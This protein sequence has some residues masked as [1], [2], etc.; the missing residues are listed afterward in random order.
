MP[1]SIL[2]TQC[3]QNDFVKLLGKHDPL[4][5]RL[6]IGYDEAHRLMGELPEEGPV[7]RLMQWAYRTDPADLEVI[8]IRDWHDANDPAQQDHLQQ[9]GAHCLKGTEGAAFAF[10]FIDRARE[11]H[12]VTASGLNDFINTE[13]TDCLDQFKDQPI[14]VGIVGVWTEAKVSFLSYELK[15]R[16]PNFD[17]AV[18]S[19]LTASSSTG[20]HYI[21]LD[22][23]R[24][25]LGIR[26]FSSVGDFTN[27]LTGTIPSY[28]TKNHRSQVQDFLQFEAGYNVSAGDCEL[29]AQ[30][31]REAKTV[32][33]KVLDG[34]YSGNLVLKAQATDLLGHQQVPTVIKIGERSLIAQERDSFERI[35]EILG[36]SAPNIVDFAENNERG[37]IKY[38]YA[39]MF[40]EAVQTFQQFYAQTD[41]LERICYFLDVIFQRQLGRLYDAARSERLNLLEYYE[42][43]NRYAAGVRQRAETLLGGPVHGATFDVEGHSC[44]NVCRFY[45]EDLN[46]LN[47]DLGKSHFMAYVHGD[48]NGA[49]III[50]AQNNVWLI[51]FFHTHLGHVLKDLIKFENDLLF[52]FTSINSATELAEGVRLINHLTEM[53][54]LGNPVDEKA[55]LS[56]KYP[57][58]AKAQQAVYRLR[59]YY[60]DLIETD[61]DPYQYHVAM[62]RYAMHTTSFEECNDW[63]RKLALYTAGRCAE[64]MVKR[65]SSPQGL[66]VDFINLPGYDIDRM[67]GLT[68]L[69]GRKDRGRSIS[70]DLEQLREAQISGVLCLISEDEFAEYGVEGLKAAYREFGFEV[71]YMPIKDQG[72][73]T[74]KA[75]DDTLTWMHDR[76]N[77]GQKTLIHCVGGLGRSGTLAACYLKQKLNVDGRTAIDL[78]RQSRSPR[79]IETY[80]QEQFVEDY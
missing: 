77:H 67:I 62:M 66:R 17:L 19:A 60:P 11:D 40:D 73:P 14:K 70:A 32:S 36:N 33:F 1:G 64:K 3:L 15:T 38:R 31:Y 35:R 9:F 59:S 34:G 80:I 24:E 51:D 56:F 76:L 29:L 21:A 44:Y 26:V 43:S 45:E 37:G 47:G 30:L 58:F 5:N 69:P 65:L 49:N 63:Q 25:I 28:A 7:G 68:I 2:I 74:R 57:Q 18:C 55:P 52:I 16:Y 10:D 41:D 50:D 20:M 72:I 53:Y 71:R 39:A 78:V 8:H 6:H 79:A 42:F 61:R 48:L 27:F 54:D 12:L 75:T 13:L 22:Q 4:P 23:L 46:R